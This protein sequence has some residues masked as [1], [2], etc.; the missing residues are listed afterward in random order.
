MKNVPDDVVT[1]IANA[2]WPWPSPTPVWCRTQAYALLATPEAV[3]VI[4]SMH[5]PVKE[6]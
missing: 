5:Q 3:E 1:V 2:L 6:Q 4:V